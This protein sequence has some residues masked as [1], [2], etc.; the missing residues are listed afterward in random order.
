MKTLDEY[1]SCEGCR[2]VLEIQDCISMNL[3]RLQHQRFVTGLCFDC[4]ICISGQAV[5]I[6]IVSERHRLRPVL[7]PVI[8]RR[9]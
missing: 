4:I 2:A 6:S 5:R 7:S 9:Q 8:M 1:K 3:A